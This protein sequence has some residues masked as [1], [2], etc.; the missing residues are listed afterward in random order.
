MDCAGA[1]LRDAAPELVP[2]IPSSSRMTQSNGVSASTS[3]E[4]AFPLIV[5]EIMSPRSLSPAG[6]RQLPACA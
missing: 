1:A 5:S 3:S 4:Y 6:T 2:V